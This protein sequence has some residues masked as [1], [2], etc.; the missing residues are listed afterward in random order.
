M[1]E[2][3]REEEKIM[4]SLMATSL[5]WRTHSARTNIIHMKA[6]FT[7]HYNIKH[8][9]GTLHVVGPQGKETKHEKRKYK[10]HNQLAGFLRMFVF[11]PDPAEPVLEQVHH[12]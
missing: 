7:Y 9:S 12:G 11:P 5:R 8:G 4:P 2:G 3:E 1:T 6:V 10:T